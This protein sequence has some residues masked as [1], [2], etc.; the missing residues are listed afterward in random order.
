MCAITG[1][2]KYKKN[3][4]GLVRGFSNLLSASGKRGRDGFGYSCYI[5]PH[6]EEIKGRL[7]T[8][9][10]DYD[11]ISRIALASHF[12]MANH[13]AEPTTEYIPEKKETDQQPYKYGRWSMVHN[14]TIAN[15]KEI[16]KRYDINPPTKIDSY[17]VPVTLQYGT[18][19]QELK[20]SMAVL[21]TNGGAYLAYRNYKPLKIIYSSFHATW[22]FSSLS[23]VL[24]FFD[25]TFREIPFPPYSIAS[26]FKSDGECLISTTRPMNQHKALVI[27]S[28]GLDSTTVAK[29]AVEQCE[30][31]TLLHFLYGC[32]AE[33]NE[34]RAVC[35]IAKHLG[36]ETLME[37]MYWLKRLGGSSLTEDKPIQKGLAGAEFAHEWVPARNT[38]MIGVAASIADKMDVGK[39]YLGLNLEEGGAYPDNTVEFYERFNQVLDV[40]TQARPQ[41]VNPLANLMKKEIV[42]LAYDIEAPIHLSW[43]CY[44][45]GEI[46]C[47]NCGPCIMRRIGHEMIGKKDG[48]MYAGAIT[49]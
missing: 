3:G 16:L 14:G 36:C 42:K 1:L 21:A 37:D 40:G 13:R 26:D 10:T 29:L 45:G 11:A 33:N 39:I 18:F 22:I 38:A 23:N 47:G 30:E 34:I 49:N 17:T 6:V 9:P 20:G 35:D 48:M 25:N 5:R 32:K 12:F 19:P 7:L 2:I 4:E 43:S 41:I 28:G 46:H 44:H 8:P 27:C 31:V 24:D 15:D